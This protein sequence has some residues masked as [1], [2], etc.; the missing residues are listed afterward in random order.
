MYKLN[1]FPV[2]ACV[3]DRKSTLLLPYRKSET[4]GFYSFRYL[5]LRYIACTKYTRCRYLCTRIFIIKDG[6]CLNY[7]S[8]SRSRECQSMLVTH[9][10]YTTSQLVPQTQTSAR[11][12]N[13][14]STIA[15]ISHFRCSVTH[16]HL[17]T[18]S[19]NTNITFLISKVDNFFGYDLDML[20]IVSTKQFPQNRDSWK[21]INRI[22]F[23]YRN[24]SK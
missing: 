2:P 18:K 14:R 11:E 1:G 17:W 21:F 5:I 20:V 19:Q 6:W 22:P 10:Q 9:I 15:M 7:I 3:S 23:G 24:R 12:R 4:N 13:K 16:N 8:T